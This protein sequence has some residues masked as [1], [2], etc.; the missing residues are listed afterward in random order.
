MPK[1]KECGKTV[2]IKGKFCS[3][4]KK[5]RNIEKSKECHSK[6]RHDRIAQGLCVN[7][8]G[9]KDI[10]PRPELD[11]YIKEHGDERMP[12]FITNKQL[13]KSTS[14]YKCYVE[15]KMKTFPESIIKIEEQARIEAN[16]TPEEREAR[17]K[18]RREREKAQNK[19]RRERKLAE[20]P[21]L[22]H[23]CMVNDKAEGRLW[24]EKCLNAVNERAM[25]KIKTRRKKGVC[26]VCKA[27]SGGDQLCDACKVPQREYSIRWWRRVRV[28][29]AEAGLCLRCGKVPSEPGTKACAACAKSAAESNKKSRAERAAAA[30][31]QK[32]AAKKKTKQTKT[33]APEKAKKEPPKQEEPKEQTIVFNNDEF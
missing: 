30:K 28:E 33:P 27:D 5:T 10:P 24:C 9:S 14:C 6:R 29:R 7:C 4:C 1:C 13:E 22:C 8:G 16:M 3:E 31:K 20:N 15:R 12:P 23:H 32:A 17:D 21:N 18:A 11:E 25:K 26:I 2:D 19:K